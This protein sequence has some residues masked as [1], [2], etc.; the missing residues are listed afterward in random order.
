MAT[1]TTRLCLALLSLG[2]PALL[3]AVPA[4]AQSRPALPGELHAGTLEVPVN[5]S[6][7]VNADRPIAKAMIGNDDVADILPLTDRS[8]YVLGKKMGTTSLTLYD[9]RGRVI[10]IMDVA[11]GPDV[12]LLN[13]QLRDLLPGQSVEARISNDSIVLTG[14][15]SSAGAA[16][17]AAR[18]AKAYAGEKVINL[19][20]IGS[21]QQVM[22]EVRFAEVDRSSGKEFGISAFGN[23]AGGSFS[24]VV[25]RGSN[26]TPNNA[27]IGILTL[28]SL[29]GQNGIFRQ[30]ITLGSLSLQ[31]ILNAMET[32]GLARTLA[33][34]TLI[35]L[36]GERASFLAGGE[37]PI[38]VAQS[39]GGGGAGGN[40]GQAITVEFKT[41][42]V[43]LAFTPTVLSDN[44][45]N[46]I[47]EP[48][49]SE[50]D[51]TA[52]LTLNGITIPGLRTRR[53]N[54]TLE[55]RDGESFAIAGLLQQD[56]KVQISQMP[57]LGSLPI[58]GTLFRSTRYQ[59]GETELLIVVTPRLVAPIK[60][61]Q[62]RLPTDRVR[63]PNDVETFLLG[64]P[65]Q[66]RE[67]PPVADPKKGAAPGLQ[68]STEGTLPAPNKADPAPS[69]AAATPAPAKDDDYEF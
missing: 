52:S 9:A 2:A 15:V 59:K 3:T 36:S 67:L 64:Q 33:Q 4:A 23:S 38:P 32:K 48:E 24:G 53:V 54:T 46:L 16:D 44:T 17:R 41:F 30:D 13:S 22:L 61:S 69:G 14:T 60:P 26:M 49:V 63:D 11:V 62:V 68:S 25:G 42:G 58:I 18:L 27:G 40:N 8:I 20:S 12:E 28:D 39:G 34:P 37:F 65:Y 35:A 10:A 6:Q 47:V 5:K 31:G 45:I 29:T 1:R 43:S 66:P 51:P 57:L 50:I 19:I 7:I 21:S 56:T 55:L